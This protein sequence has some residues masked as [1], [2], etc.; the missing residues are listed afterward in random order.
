M[1]FWAFYDYMDTSKTIGTYD[2]KVA[3]AYEA[4][5][6]ECGLSCSAYFYQGTN[7][8]LAIV[9]ELNNNRPCH[10]MIHNHYKYGNHSVLALGY[11][12]FRYGSAYSTYIRIADGWTNYPSRYVWGP[13]SGAWNYVVVIPR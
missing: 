1:F 5:F 9:E 7:N 11:S 8:G 6:K 3:G 4:Y 2:T 10:L 12:Q 13:C